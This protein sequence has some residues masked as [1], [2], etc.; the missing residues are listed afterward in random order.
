MERV[1]RQV[2]RRPTVAQQMEHSLLSVVGVVWGQHEC[3]GGELGSDD[4]TLNALR[5]RLT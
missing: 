4:T 3:L 5:E 1:K 2:I